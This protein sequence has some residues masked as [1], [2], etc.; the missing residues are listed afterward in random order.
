MKKIKQPAVHFAPE[1]F[2]DPPHPI[3][4]LVVGAGGTGSQVLTQLAR[5]HVSLVAL[6]HPGFYVRL[7]DADIVTEAN[8]ARQMFA[9]S[10][11][12]LNKASVLVSRINRFFGLRWSAVN[13]MFSE[14]TDLIDGKNNITITCTDTI[15]SR[16]VI[17]NYLKKRVEKLQPYQIPVYWMDF[18]NTLN[19]GQV[20]LGNIMG[21]KQPKSEYR[22]LS[23]LPTLFDIY[24]KL[25]MSPEDVDTPSCSLAEA[26]QRQD[27]FINSMLAQLGCKMLWDL[28][29][30]AKLDYHGVYV[31]LNPL[32]I[33]TLPIVK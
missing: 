28:F 29:R 10:D 3:T 18:G 20:I 30:N 8:M 2:L 14:T 26:L 11:L 15:D 24:P 21:Q 25:P 7:M 22:T 19:S 9:I 31:N 1:Y 13:E 17:R 4:I 5:M 32:N 33:S 12:H 6:G 23:T 27:L 16:W